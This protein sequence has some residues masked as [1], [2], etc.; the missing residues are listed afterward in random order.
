V[1]NGAKRFLKVF[2]SSVLTNRNLLIEKLGANRILR[3]DW[4]RLA[5]SINTILAKEFRT[6][7]PLFPLHCDN[8]CY[9]VDNS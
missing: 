2:I 1:P 4:H 3:T 7:Y 5:Q 9:I 6:P 8:E